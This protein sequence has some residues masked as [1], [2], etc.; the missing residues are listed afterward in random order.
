M[1]VPGPLPDPLPVLAVDP[2]QGGQ[3][4]PPPDMRLA[5][6]GLWFPRLDGRPLAAWS[7]AERQ[8]ACR[9]TPGFMHADGLFIAFETQPVDYIPTA[10]AHLLL[11]WALPCCPPPRPL[12]PM[13]VSTTR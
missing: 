9:K 6:A 3:L 11:R 13:N 2:L 10:N 5:L 1:P 4:A 12:P 8:E 7:A